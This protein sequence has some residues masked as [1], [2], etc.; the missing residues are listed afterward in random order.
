LFS[1]LL[2]GNGADG[3][4]TIAANVAL[5]QRDIYYDTLTVNTGVVVTESGI[6]IFAKTSITLSGTGK[7]HANG[8]DVAAVGASAGGLG[9]IQTVRSVPGGTDGGTSTVASAAAGGN[10]NAGGGSP[11]GMPLGGQGGAGGNGSGGVGGGPGG[12][13]VAV[14]QIVTPPND[15]LTAI[16]GP[17]APLMFIIADID[18]ANPRFISAYAYCGGSGGGAGGWSAGKAGGAGA[19]A[20]GVLFIYAA[21]VLGT[22]FLEAKGGKGGDGDPTGNTGG[23]GGG[24]GG[25]IVLVT[26]L[27]S[28]GVTVSVAGGLGGVKGGTGMNGSAGQNGNLFQHIV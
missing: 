11:A 12:G 22:G 18:P 20:A 26:K 17:L 10:I 8:T 9:A 16:M 27:L 4:V 15:V 1:S 5:E 13:P 23:G 28:G 7:I 2:F 21:L 3:N 19:G 25:A 24:G 14:N 6:R